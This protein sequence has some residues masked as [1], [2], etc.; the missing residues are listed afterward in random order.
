MRRR[1]SRRAPARSR[2]RRRARRERRA[3]LRARRALSRRARLRAPFDP[4]RLA[5]RQRDGDVQSSRAQG[6]RHEHAGGPLDDVEQRE[7]KR[8]PDRRE[9]PRSR[10][11]TSRESSA[12]TSPEERV[13]EHH[14]CDSVACEREHARGGGGHGEAQPAPCTTCAAALASVDPRRVSGRRDDR[15]R[16]RRRR[17][18]DR[19]AIKY[20]YENDVT[21][22]TSSAAARPQA[23]HVDAW[24][25]IEHAPA[26]SN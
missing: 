20:A 13:A 14:A 25:T 1:R 3:A 16:R 8:E 21:A 10:T 17:D 22:P 23:D 9:G 12:P 24:S 15:Q 5:Q 18:Q 7:C 19:G 4:E 11:T 2:P 6:D 26:T